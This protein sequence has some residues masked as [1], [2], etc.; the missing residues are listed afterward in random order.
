MA[1]KTATLYIRSASGYALP[2]K[3]LADISTGETYDIVWYEGRR[4]HAR[5]LGRDA[6]GA[7]IALIN[8]ERVEERTGAGCWATTVRAY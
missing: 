5:S 1:N 4:K 6:G 7:Q 2:P 8:P 3:K